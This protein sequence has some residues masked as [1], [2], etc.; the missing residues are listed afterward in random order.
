MC[1]YICIL[2]FEATCWEDNGNNQIEIIEFP[3]ILIK[4]TPRNKCK[5][6]ATFSEF[7]KPVINPNLS[8]F[9]IKLTG[10]TQE[11]VNSSAIFKNVYNKHLQ[12]LQNNIPNN[13]KMFFITCGH[14]D[15]RDIL[16]KEVKRCNSRIYH[17]YKNYCNLKDDFTIFYNYHPNSMADM[18]EYLNIPFEGKLHSGIDDTKKYCKNCC[19]DD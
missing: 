7:V 6:V 12:W 5:Y 8:E 9:C 14:W 3:S 15:I 18:L 10:I 11:Q 17:Y 4:I 1:K 19:E 2:D 16:H 13:S